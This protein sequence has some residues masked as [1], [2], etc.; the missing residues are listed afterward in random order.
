MAKK[1]PL[2]KR[3]AQLIRTFTNVGVAEELATSLA[4][5]VQGEED[6]V[7]A[8]ISEYKSAVSG[9]LVALYVGQN[10][11]HK[12]IIVSNSHDSATN[13]L[14]EAY[15]VTQLDWYQEVFPNANIARRSG[16][17]SYWDT[18]GCGVVYTAGI[19]SSL[20][21]QEAQFL[22]V[23]DPYD[24]EDSLRPV[25]EWFTCVAKPRLV[26]GGR[27]CVLHERVSDFDLVN[28][29]NLIK[30]HDM[31]KKKPQTQN[32]PMPEVATTIVEKTDNA[33]ATP[34]ELVSET[35]ASFGV[36]QF[37][38][39][40]WMNYLGKRETTSAMQ[41]DGVGCVVKT[42]TQ[43]MGSLSEALAFVPGVKIDNVL[44]GGI[45]VGRKLVKIKT[46]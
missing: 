3:T 29:F 30:G 41:I 5:L 44:E 7:A 6:E 20:V 46:T 17:S 14:L 2:T 26:P 45:I 25:N 35:P 28:K 9:L 24:T 42:T 21:G 31:T 18:Q 4:K 40:Y 10:P 37:Q 13:I 43:D 33:H 36:E 22:L 34:P 19:G 8:Y 16:E 38:T 27:L 1:K 23:S 12:A 39:L 15:A 11:E 32:T